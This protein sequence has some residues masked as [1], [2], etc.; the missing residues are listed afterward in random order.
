MMGKEKIL[1]LEIF[2]YKYI[3]IFNIY[4]YSLINIFLKVYLIVLKET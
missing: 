4:I 2:T 3:Y 1:P